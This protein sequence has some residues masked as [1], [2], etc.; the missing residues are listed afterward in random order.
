MLTLLITFFSRRF[1]LKLRYVMLAAIG[2]SVTTASFASINQFEFGLMESTDDVTAINQA[3]VYDTKRG[4]G[5]DFDTANSS[6]FSQH[7]VVAEQTLYFSIRLPEGR[8]QIDL[9]IGSDLVDSVTTVKAESRRLMLNQVRMTK[10]QSQTQTIMVDVRRPRINQSEQIML[11]DREKNDLNWD[12]K[13]TL[14]FAPQSAVKSIKVRAVSS[15]QTLYLAG[16]STVT[17]Q[18]VEPWASWGQLITQYLK[19]QIVVAN[20]A[21]SGASLFSFKAEHRLDKIMSLLKPGDYVFIQF[22]HNDEKRRGDGIGP[23]HSYSELLQEYVT[24]VR[25]R[26]GVAVLLT[27]VER[28]FFNPDG[29][30]QATHGDYPAAVRAVAA[31]MQVTLI[32]LTQLS[33]VLYQSWGDARSR[34]AFVQYPANTFISQPKALKDNTHFNYFGANEIALCV[35]KGLLDTTLPLA[36]YV[37][38]GEHKYSPLQPNNF[39]NWS[40]PMSPRFIATKPEGS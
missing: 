34:Q 17:D 30:V 3:L 21:V 23:W 40:V 15:I 39:E 5:F 26:G 25:E 8:Y 31:K 18:D 36:N 37:I 2:L 20:Y 38:S 28:R 9:N 6:R 16:D 29:S 27:P 35:I 14:E 10:G 19:P 7:G 4:F 13:L 11:K 32:D 22:A 12:D 33:T 24:R 1:R